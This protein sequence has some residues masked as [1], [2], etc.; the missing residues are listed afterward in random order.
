LLSDQSL[1]GVVGVTIE[2]EGVE[3][4]RG[5]RYCHRE[6]VSGKTGRKHCLGTEIC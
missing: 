6:R 3:L 1:Y 4:Q 5:F 2:S